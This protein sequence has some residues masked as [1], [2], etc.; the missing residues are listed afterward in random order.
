LLL[1][2]QFFL[3]VLIFV[4]GIAVFIGFILL[5]IVGWVVFLLFGL[6]G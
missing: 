2:L 3:L 4:V 1:F 5:F 6:L